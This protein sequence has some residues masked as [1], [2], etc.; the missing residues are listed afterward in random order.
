MR[1]NNASALGAREILLGV[2]ILIFFANNAP[3][4]GEFRGNP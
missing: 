1:L 3:F 4:R 2:V